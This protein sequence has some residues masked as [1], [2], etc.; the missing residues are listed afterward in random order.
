VSG[1]TWHDF[2]TVGGQTDASGN[3]P[4]QVM[5]KDGQRP[6]VG[7][8]PPLDF[9]PKPI[10]R[11]LNQENVPSPDKDWVTSNMTEACFCSDKLPVS[12]ARRREVRAPPQG[13][14]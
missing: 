1:P 8:K 7:P 11:A 10:E 9:K 5:S 14:G 6:V 12:D 3:G 4:D 13:E 2:H